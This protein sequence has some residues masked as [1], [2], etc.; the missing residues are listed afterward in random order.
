MVPRARVRLGMPRLD[1]LL[2]RSSNIKIGNSPWTGFCVT[3]L[4][5]KE[6]HKELKLHRRTNCPVSLISEHSF[7]LSHKFALIN[8]THYPHPPPPNVW[9]R[10]KITINSVP[11]GTRVSRQDSREAKDPKYGPRLFQGFT[12]TSYTLGISIWKMDYEIW[13]PSTWPS[14]LTGQEAQISGYGQYPAL[15]AYGSHTPIQ[16]HFLSGS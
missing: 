7:W 14:L 5:K 15:R 6:K 9:L 3:N 13:D 8:L 2:G 16:A 4:N 10:V 1:L 12:E 11:Q